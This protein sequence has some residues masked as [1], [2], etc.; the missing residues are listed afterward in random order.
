MKP[1]QRNTIRNQSPIG[2]AK[3][4]RQ[5]PA[6]TVA[7][8]RAWENRHSNWERNSYK[9]DYVN[10]V[11]ATKL[12][13]RVL[14]PGN[15]TLIAAQKTLTTTQDKLREHTPIDQRLRGIQGSIERIQHSIQDN[16][17]YMEKLRDKLKQAE[18]YAEELQDKL[19]KTEEE[20]QDLNTIYHKM[21]EAELE[22]P[23]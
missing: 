13:A 6:Y 4:Q 11:R 14:E 22:E 7:E 8:W 20:Q 18:A 10:A 9:A 21:Q 3:P 19:R 1:T 5:E 2:R 23:L 17:W 16:V 15:P 12:M